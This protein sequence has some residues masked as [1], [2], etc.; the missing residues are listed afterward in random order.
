[1]GIIDFIVFVIYIIIFN[2]LFKLRRKKYSDPVLKRYHA[3]GFWVKVFSCFT[4]SMFV[5]Y[6]SQGDTTALYY[7][8]G[9]NFFKLILKDDSHISLLFNSAEEFDETLLFN[10]WNL[11]YLKTS[12]N[13]MVTRIVGF[14]A[15]P[16]FGQF[17]AINLF[18]SLFA[19]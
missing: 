7:P 4:Y 12:S 2:I 3:I 11:G 14:L 1:M 16:T 10:T 15:F 9:V 19:F 5:L 17:M 6:I 13:Y 8:E 18:F